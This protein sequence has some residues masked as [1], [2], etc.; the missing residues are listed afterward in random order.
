MITDTKVRVRTSN[1]KALEKCFW[2][3]V[4]AEHP[5]IS[6]HTKASLRSIAWRL[7]FGEAVSWEEYR[8]TMYAF[9]ASTRD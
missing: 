9:L 1:L 2:C 3:Q 8:S 6:P 7:F 5:D 4:L